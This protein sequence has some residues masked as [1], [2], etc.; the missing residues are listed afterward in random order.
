MRVKFAAF[1]AAIAVSISAQN[2][3]NFEA[4]HAELVTILRSFVRIQTPNSNE[5]LGARFLKN[6]L[7]HEGIPSEILEMEPGRGSLVARIKGNGKK[8]PLLLLGHIDTVGVEREKW[9][10]DPFEGVVRDGFLYGRGARDDKG[11]TIV[12]LEV[13]LQ[14]ARLKIPLDRDVIYVAEAG[15]EGASYLGIDFL[16]EKHWDKIECEFALNEGGGIYE[17]D[18][19]ITAVRVATAEKVPRPLMLT[20]KGTSGHGSR[21]RADNPIVHLAMAIAKFDKS[22]PPMRLNDT[23]REYFARV[24]EISSPEKAALYRS[25]EKPETQ[26]KLR[27]EDIGANSMLRTTVSP[28]IIKGG[29]TF[30]VIPGD[31]TANL[32]VRALPDEDMSKFVETLTK[33]IDDPAVTVTPL[34]GKR[35]ATAPSR[36]DKEMFRTR[37]A[38]QKKHFP[39]AITVP[40]MSPGATD[41][42]QLRAKGVQAYGIGPVGTEADGLL[43]HGN[44][45][46]ISVPGLKLFLQYL[47]DVTVEIAGAK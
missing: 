44:D 12:N 19:K 34:G 6:F 31:A 17:E 7:D 14:L 20:A 39:G 35:P 11:M 43:I 1:L 27:L 2:S 3:P 18:G 24:A 28:N 40:Y 16:V 21:P 33:L 47:W 9:T 42:A 30:N 29:F 23:T 36:V 45:E 32:D 26:E 25:L 37:E 8:R 5:T 38:M 13:F 41:S 4:A 15:E 46:R 22:Q 10:V